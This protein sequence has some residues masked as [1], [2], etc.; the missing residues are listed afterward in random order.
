MSNHLDTTTISEEEIRI[1]LF[2]QHDGVRFVLQRILENCCDLIHVT[3]TR[4]KNFIKKLIDDN[5]VDI[6]IT[7][8]SRLDRIG[9]ELTKYASNSDTEIK[10][11]WVTVLGCHLFRK[12]MR[13][14]G[15]ARCFE[16]PLEAKTLRKGM[17]AIMES[18]D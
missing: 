18:L 7:E 4:N 14:L 17:H 11:V 2:E 8:L 9:L 5:Q 13:A 1:V 16:K 12:E 10:I 6:L 3:A 15:V